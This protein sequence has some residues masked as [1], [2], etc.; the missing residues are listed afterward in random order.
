MVFDDKETEIEGA[1]KFAAFID[2]M[3]RL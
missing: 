3:K 2:T 1:Y